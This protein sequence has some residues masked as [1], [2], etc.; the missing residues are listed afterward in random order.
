MKRLTHVNV[1]ALLL[2]AQLTGGWWWAPG[3]VPNNFYTAGGQVGHDVPSQGVGTTAYTTEESLTILPD[4]RQAVGF[5]TRDTLGNAYVWVGVYD[6]NSN[7]FH[8]LSN[9]N[10]PDLLEGGNVRDVRV[11]ARPDG[12]LVAA[13]IRGGNQ[14]LMTSQ[15]D[16]SSWRDFSSGVDISEPVNWDGSGYQPVDSYD[17]DVDP[18]TG[19]P[20]YVFN[21][22]WWVFANRWLPSANAF[23]G[24]RANG[25]YPVDIIHDGSASYYQITH[26]RLSVAPSS[27][28]PSVAW[29]GATT[30]GGLSPV[31][32]L[33]WSGSDW[34][35]LGSSQ[36]API[37][38]KGYIEIDVDLWGFVH[39]V[40]EYHKNPYRDVFY[41]RCGSIGCQ[42]NLGGYAD[43]ITGFGYFPDIVVTLNGRPDIVYYTPPL[44]DFTIKVTRWKAATRRWEG[45]WSIAHT[46]VVGGSTFWWMSLA[47]DAQNR[48][49]L[50]FTK[51]TLRSGTC[52]PGEVWF[53]RQ[54]P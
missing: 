35:P 5:W 31:G 17:M 37:A 14:R 29:S 11:K 1:L 24:R 9:S 4:G 23:R 10:G 40:G 13:W 7:T 28:D 51:C 3:P 47:H 8:G 38:S 46:P 12:T 49:N 16:G 34:V 33:T 41:T 30:T 15:W 44:N 45:L 42:G 54:L 53:T 2:S 18:F 39:L 32:L 26:S 48:I 50:A 6:Q 20:S 21:N 25:A 27:G 43:Q 22:R 19:D 52:S 36:W